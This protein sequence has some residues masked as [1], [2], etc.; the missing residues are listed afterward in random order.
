M[1]ILVKTI[2]LCFLLLQSSCEVTFKD[3]TTNRCYENYDV[4]MECEGDGRSDIYDSATG[5]VTRGCTKIRVDPNYSLQ[6]DCTDG[7]L[8]R[9]TI[10]SF[11]TS[12]QGR[13]E[14]RELGSATVRASLPVYG[15]T[16][17]TV[18]FC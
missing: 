9:L 4:I 13:W 15:G 5:Q 3:L 6:E 16:V 8:V 2:T 1:Q 18:K 17:C 12:L 11:E 10:K 14:C 7:H